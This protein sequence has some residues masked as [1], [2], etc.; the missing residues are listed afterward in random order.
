MYKIIKPQ[1]MKQLSYSPQLPKGIKN[2]ENNVA[3]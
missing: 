3:I 1:R 2:K